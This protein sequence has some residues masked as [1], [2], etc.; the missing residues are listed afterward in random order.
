M[1]TPLPSNR[2]EVDTPVPIKEATPVP[3]RA[4]LTS[5]PPVALLSVYKGSWTP[6]EIARLKDIVASSFAILEGVNRVDWDLVVDTFGP[7]RTKHQILCKAVD[8]GLRGESC[9]PQCRVILIGRYNHCGQP[10]QEA[11]AEPAT[12]TVSAEP[13]REHERRGRGRRGRAGD[14]HYC[15]ICLV[16]IIDLVYCTKYLLLYIIWA[17]RSGDRWGRGDRVRRL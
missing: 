10:S 1:A 7:T 13:E 3:P 4:E 16:L 9:C 5:P 8:L 2:I 6:L 11:E 12:N 17:C 14:L 15:Y